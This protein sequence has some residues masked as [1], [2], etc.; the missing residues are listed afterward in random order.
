MSGCIYASGVLLFC[1]IVYFP[2]VLCVVSRLV[3]CWEYC[4]V[5]GRGLSNVGLKFRFVFE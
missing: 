5:L 4:E 1:V 2:P 3:V